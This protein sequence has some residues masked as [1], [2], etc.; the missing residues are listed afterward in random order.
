ML[1]YLCCLVLNSYFSPTIRN[2]TGNHPHSSGAP[3]SERSFYNVLSYPGARDQKNPEATKGREDRE[4]G[5]GK[6][7]TN[8]KRS[9]EKK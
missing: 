1:T 5:Q 2:R 3:D 7:N 4:E 8:G 6:E 9:T